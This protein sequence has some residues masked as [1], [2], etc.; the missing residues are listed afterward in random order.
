M[1]VFA[2]G[3]CGDG[4]V[5]GPVEWRDVSEH[6]GDDVGAYCCADCVV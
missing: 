6:V 4:L 2:C 3:P 5:D 1:V